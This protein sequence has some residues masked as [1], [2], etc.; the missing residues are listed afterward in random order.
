L[1]NNVN[2]ASHKK[3]EKLFEDVEEDDD[4]EDDNEEVD[5]QL[6]YAVGRQ[7][8]RSARVQNKE[9]G[10]KIPTPPL[11]S[12]DR[13]P[14]ATYTPLPLSWPP[15]PAMTTPPPASL[16]ALTGTVTLT[17]EQFNAMLTTIQGAGATTTPK[18]LSRRHIAKPSTWNTVDGNPASWKLEVETFMHATDANYADDDERIA[19]ILLYLADDARLWARPI[20]KKDPECVVTIENV[21]V[22]AWDSIEAFWAFFDA[23]WTSRNTVE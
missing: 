15:S 12:T 16:P 21:P 14:H 5:R 19:T 3:P 1:I 9:A 7:E 20:L 10:V 8:G 6:E 2:I 17:A 11:P 22:A 18:S 13:A 23:E 4:K